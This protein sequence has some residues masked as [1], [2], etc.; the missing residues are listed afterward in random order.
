MD[1]M[2]PL[3]ER[4]PPIRGKLSRLELGRFV[5]LQDRG[6]LD[7]ERAPSL[8]RIEPVSETELIALAAQANPRGYA[9]VPSSS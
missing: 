8:M 7:L 4:R 6:M 1:K 3:F 2:K 9:G 5:M